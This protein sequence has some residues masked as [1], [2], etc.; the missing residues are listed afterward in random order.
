MLQED[1]EAAA[2]DATAS[3]PDNVSN[4]DKLEMYAL[5]KQASIGD[6]N[7]A[8]PGIFDPK[9][10]AK[11]SAWNAKKGTSQ[12]EAMQKYIELVAALKA[13]YGTKK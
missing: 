8:Q 3:L 12:E 6:C 11:W 10:R 5:Y 9:G 7:T 1:F 13:K 4:D 2:L